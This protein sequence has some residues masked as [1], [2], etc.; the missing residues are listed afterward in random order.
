[1]AVISHEPLG[2]V[3]PEFARRFERG[4]ERTIS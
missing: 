3:L 1:M 2:V 4:D